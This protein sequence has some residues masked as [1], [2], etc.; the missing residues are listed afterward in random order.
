MRKMKVIMFVLFIQIIGSIT[1]VYGQD[2]FLAVQQN[3]ISEVKSLME[4]D[5]ET[6]AEKNKDGMQP[7]HIASAYGMINIVKLLIN[8]NAGVN[9]RDNLGN[10]PLHYVAY[11]GNTQIAEFLVSKGAEINIKNY[12]GGSPFLNSLK[13]GMKELAEYYIKNGAEI[14]TDGENGIK[15]LQDAVKLNLKNLIDIILRKNVNIDVKSE[16]GIGLL[17]GAAENGNTE[18]VNLLIKKGVDLFSLN[19]QGGSLLHSTAKGGDAQLAELV[20]NKGLDINGR[21]SFTFTPLHEAVIN[22]KKEIVELLLLKNA[23]INIL[24]GDGSTSLWLAKENSN[25]EITELLTAKGADQSKKQFPEL[26]GDCFGMKSPGTTPEIFAPGIVSNEYLQEF[27]GTFSPD[28]TEFFFTRRKTVQDQRIWYMKQENGVWI[29]PVP[30]PFTYDIFEFESHISP[31]GK[32]LYYGSRRPKP[33]DT[34]P[35]ASA[36][37][38]FVK[39]SGTGWGEPQY[40]STVINEVMPMYMSAALDGTLYFTA[41]KLR[42]IYKSELINGIYG[43][44]ERLSDQINYI[45]AAHPYISPDED[46]IIF[47]GRPKDNLEKDPDIYVSFRKTDGTWTKAKKVK[48]QV[49]TADNEIAASV[50]PDGKYL[51]FE[52]NRAGSMNIYRVSSG[53]LEKY[54]R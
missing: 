34:K 15:L 52:S 28:G 17:H 7:L 40:L 29:S 22:G 45:S 14:D 9:A 50:S 35:N 18:L 8:N 31:D 19:R 44:P 48:D 23:D 43:A 16:T 47:D 27:A 36:A 46:Y 20:I 24:T 49:S 2:I 54:S 12:K 51:F 5:P 4:K 38:W 41:N 30:A 11:N 33:G 39:K 1:F 10:P 3:N 21:N 25:Q 32:T 13:M 42:G 53:I 26:K 6:V 37:I